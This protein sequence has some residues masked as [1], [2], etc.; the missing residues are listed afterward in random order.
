MHIREQI[1]SMM[2][3]F[4]AMIQQQ[5]RQQE[6]EM[7]ENQ[8]AERKHDSGTTGGAGQGDEPFSR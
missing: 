7:T 8:P 3:M 1:D 2:K 4:P 6:K 5:V